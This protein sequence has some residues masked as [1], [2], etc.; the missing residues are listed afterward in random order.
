MKLMKFRNIVLLLAASSLAG[1]D[2]MDCDESSDYTKEEIFN[3]YDRSKRMVTNIYSYLPHDFGD[4]GT[5]NTVATTATNADLTG[6]AMLDAATDDAIHIYK[7]AAIWR[8]VDGTWSAVRTVDDVW[9]NYYTAIRAANL[10]LKESE[11]EDFKDWEFSDNYADMIKNHTNYAYEV[12]FLRAFYYFELI[13]RYHN[14][15]LVLDVLTPEE[16]N[17][18]QPSSFETVADFIVKECTELADGLLPVDYSGFADKESG[19]ATRGAAL[20]LKARVTLYMASPLFAGSGAQEEK[21]KNA[22][23]AA[24]AVINPAAGLGYRLDNF[25]NLF[26][27]NNNTSKEVIMARSIGEFGAFER[28]NFPMGVEGGKTSTCPTQN[29]VDAFETTTGAPFDWNNP[30]M[31]A[32]PYA[33]R[34]PRL[35]MTVVYNDMAWPASRKMEIWEGGANGL[36]L[37]NAT[38]TGYYLRKYVNND[39]SFASGSEVTKKHHNWVL[40]R[41]AEVLLNYA[42]AMVNAFHNPDYTDAD[43]PLSAREAVNQVRQRSDVGMPEFP[44]GMSEADFLKRLKNERRVE[45][46]FEGHRFWDV[47]RWKELDKT[48]DIYGVKVQKVGDGFQYDKFLYESRTITDKL[49]F[50]PIANTEKYKNPNLGQN[51]GW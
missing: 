22:A 37:T 49:Y 20:A 15:P 34:D 28:A 38:T 27:V 25:A 40:F 50:Y 16:A 44:V 14:V 24:Y 31:K 4:M 47:R 21:W 18:V 3:S 42:E 30:A 6:D 51:P 7:T 8:F 13:K 26:G 46:A 36:P 12:R 48:A 45:L 23:R 11:G 32:N 39:I 41:Y 29:L 5:S 1:C 19:R 33:N 9:G 10:Y 2:F 43:F 35:A 17:A